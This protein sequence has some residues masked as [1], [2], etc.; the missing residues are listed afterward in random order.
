MVGWLRKRE[1][2]VQLGSKLRDLRLQLTDWETRESEIGAALRELL[3][4]FGT[5]ERTGDVA[6]SL[7]LAEQVL[8]QAEA[9]AGRRRTLQSDPQAQEE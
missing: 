8:G 3:A 1:T 6:G 7:D 4:A 2:A 5:G 9:A